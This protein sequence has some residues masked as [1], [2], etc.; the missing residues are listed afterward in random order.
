MV[1]LS[2]IAKPIIDFVSSTDRPDAPG[3]PAPKDVD[4]GFVTLSWEK[5]DFD[6]GAK[7]MGY[8]V[9]KKDEDFDWAPVTCFLF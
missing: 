8:N 2:V 5:P 9:E 4:K 1:F 7:I 3:K 6:G